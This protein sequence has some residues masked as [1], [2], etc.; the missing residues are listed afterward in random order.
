MKDR[1]PNHSVEDSA[2]SK[3]LHDLLS[4]LNR[5]NNSNASADRP[6]QSSSIKDLLDNIKQNDRQAQLQQQRL[7]ASREAEEID[8][9][10]GTFA[11]ASPLLEQ[12]MIPET[13]SEQEEVEDLDFLAEVI[14]DRI[15]PNLSIKMERKGFHRSNRIFSRETI[16]THRMSSMQFNPLTSPSESAK[17]N[18]L[19]LL[20]QEIEH[21]LYRRLILEQERQGR[22]TGCLPW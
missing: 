6:A 16:E 13:H 17:H 22:S 18:V 15:A 1:T 8:S 12:V 14:C 11:P 9:L 2:D 10:P 21:L 4:Q 3:K 7:D 19:E 5:E 20:S